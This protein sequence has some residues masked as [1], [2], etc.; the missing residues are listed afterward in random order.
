MGNDLIFL[1]LFLNEVNLAKADVVYYLHLTILTSCFWSTCEAGVIPN[2]LP[3][4][5]LSSVVK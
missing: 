2:S 1:F 4:P 3:G 5:L